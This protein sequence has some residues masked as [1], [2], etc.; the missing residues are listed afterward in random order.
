ME[1]ISGVYCILNLLNNKRYIGKSNNIYKRW[2]G[3]INDLRKNKFHNKHLQSAWNK[4]GEESFEFYIIG[5]YPDEITAQKEIEWIDYFDS[6]NNGYNQT[7]GGEGSVG[8]VCS[9]EKRQKLRDSH[10]GE[11]HNRTRPVYCIELNRTFW[12]AKE[13]QD[14]Y[15]K[16]YKVRAS[17]I[18]ECCMGNQVYSGR[19]EDGTRLHW[20]YLENK[21]VFITPINHRDKPV[22]CIEL[23]KI[24]ENPI[25]AQNDCKIFKAHSKNIVKCC[26]AD[27]QHKTCGCL[28][29]GTKLTWRY[30][31]AEEINK[32]FVVL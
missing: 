8:A 28:S 24:F 15:G 16:L 18:T 3:E 6:Y 32:Y 12:G 13:A 30:A 4:Y 10:M 22:Y 17:G 20:C 31:T 2:A 21:D 7:L 23:N 25:T 9:D 29:D 1:V 27:S 5:K 11:K 26:N 14:L 19:F